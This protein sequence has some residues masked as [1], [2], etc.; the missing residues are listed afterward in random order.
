MFT[1]IVDILHASRDTLVPDALG[2]VAI[3]AM[4]MGL[5]HLPGL[6]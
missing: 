3:A 6:G 5:L 1:R 4:T 2:V